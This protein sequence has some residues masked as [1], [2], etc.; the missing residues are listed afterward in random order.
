[1]WCS[2]AQQ[3]TNPQTGLVT[4][5]LDG[6]GANFGISCSA[7]ATFSLDTNQDPVPT[8]TVTISSSSTAALRPRRGTA[9]Q[10][11]AFLLA[12]PGLMFLGVG[13]LTF[14]GLRGRRA[15]ATFGVL[16]LISL[17]LFLPACGGGFSGSFSKHQGGGTYTLTVMG[18]VAGTP[19]GASAPQVI[20]VEIFNIVLTVAPS[21]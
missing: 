16:L 8:F 20:G 19:P 15:L 1:M 10:Q 18:T 3:V 21:G 11:F 5:Q 14:A 12:I 17:L 7:P 9:A 13:V 6:T 4:Y 2:A